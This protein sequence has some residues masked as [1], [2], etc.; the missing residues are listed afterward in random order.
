MSPKPKIVSFDDEPLCLVNDHDIVVGYA[1]KRDAHSGQ[2]LLH[3][4]FSIFIANEKQEILLQRRS[5]KKLLWPGF[6]SNACCSHPRK[7]ESYE[8]ATKR[9]LYEELGIC[10]SLKFTHRFKY[11]A[12][13]L[14]EGSEYE[15]CSVFF[16]ELPPFEE[17]NLNLHPEEVEAVQWLAASDIDMWVKNHPKTLTP[18][19]IKEWNYLRAT[20]STLEMKREK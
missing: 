20:F 5:A 12:S 14:N 13:Y 7:N 17:Q 2:G 6:W 16:G 4:A 8:Q 1:T 11:Q 18:W 10:A 19:F 3:R 9:R 15:L